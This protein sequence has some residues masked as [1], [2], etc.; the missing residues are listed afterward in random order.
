MKIAFRHIFK[1]ASKPLFVDL[2]QMSVAFETLHICKARSR[3]HLKARPINVYFKLENS[4]SWQ[5]KKNCLIKRRFYANQF[6]LKS[7]LPGFLQSADGWIDTDLLELFNSL[8]EAFV[9]LPLT[10]AVKIKP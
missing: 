2:S 8:Q 9:D 6:V 10:F 7:M 1:Q 4:N 5:C 3:R